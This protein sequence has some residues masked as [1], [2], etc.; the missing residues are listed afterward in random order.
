M[1]I[2]VTLIGIVAVAALG[3]AFLLHPAVQP[4]VS[5]AAGPDVSFRTFFHDNAIIG[6]TDYA[7][8]S[9]GA[10]SLTATQFANAKT[11]EENATGALTVTLPTGASLS[12]IGYLQY[13][14]DTDTKFFHASTTN[15]TLAGAT[16]LTLSAAST[17]KQVAA[18][19]TGIITCTRLGATEARLIQ[20]ILVSD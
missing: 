5:G 4:V 1:K 8:T 11:I 12:S 13:P 6:G 3:A 2:A 17:T 15:V 10:S 20:C 16:G 14:G 9:V 18:N 7:T 19:T